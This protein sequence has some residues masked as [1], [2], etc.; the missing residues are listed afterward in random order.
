MATDVLKEQLTKYLTD[1]HS[2][3][4]Q[5]L[6]QMKVAPQLAGDERIARLFA[7]H[8]AETEAHE[9]LI[10]ERL[11][12]HGTQPSKLKDLAGT[13]TGT[14]LAA[15][16]AAQPDTPGKLL[17]HAYSYEHMEE[18]AYR[19]LGP[20]AEQAG[21][22]E[23]ADVANRIGAQEHAMGERLAECFGLATDAALNALAPADLQEQVSKYLADAHAIEQQ[24]LKLLDRA[25]DMVGPPALATTYSQ[26]H[27]ETEEHQ[28]LIESQL[29]GRGSS[30]LTMLKD[31][32]LGLGAHGFGLFFRAQPDTPAKLAAFVY[33]FEHLE[34]GA[35]EMLERVALRAMDT[36]VQSLAGH[37]RGE[38]RAAAEKVWDLLDQALAASLEEQGVG[39]R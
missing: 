38:E 18:A 5:A 27:T 22:A 24:S 37:I 11:K 9:R 29:D 33:A 39:V 30:G 6:A 26:H 31:R 13:A 19:L 28:R 16:A 10:A 21:D 2:I 36:G 20:L 4:Q 25:K 12:A 15:F 7:D 34:I 32:A 23:T 8:L 14:C 3:E 17:V 1:A 35:Y